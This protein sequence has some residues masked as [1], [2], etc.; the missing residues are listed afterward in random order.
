MFIVFG[1]DDFSSIE[2]LKMGNGIEKLQEE[3]RR[4]CLRITWEEKGF[5]A[6]KK[7]STKF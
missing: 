1:N 6:P 3:S 4:K 2:M 5:F 7:S